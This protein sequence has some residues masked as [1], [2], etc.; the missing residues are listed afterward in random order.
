MCEHSS[1]ANGKMFSGG[2]AAVGT[3]KELLGMEIGR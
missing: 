3:V 2:R 1:P